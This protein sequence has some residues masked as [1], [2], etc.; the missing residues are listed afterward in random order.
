MKMGV[1]HTYGPTWY[2][3]AITAITRGPYNH[4]LIYF[5]LDG[6]GSRVYFESYWKKDKETG[7]TGMRGPIDWEELVEWEQRDP[8]RRLFVQHL[9]YEDVVCEKAYAYCL[10]RKKDIYYPHWQLWHNLKSALFGSGHPARSISSDKW[11]CSETIGRVLA[12]IDPPTA[13]EYLRLGD[14]LFDQLTPS[15]KAFGICEALIRFAT[16]RRQ[17][18][19]SR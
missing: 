18:H 1:A 6:E 19:A 10:Q 2:G 14:I 17:R 11:T 7:K 8:R 5:D 3:R 9:P 4:S 15:G 12:Y 16:D 13:L